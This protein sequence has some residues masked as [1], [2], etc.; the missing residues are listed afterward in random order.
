MLFTGQEMKYKIKD[1]RSKLK[2]ISKIGTVK[3]KI[4]RGDIEKSARFVKQTCTIL[5]KVCLYPLKAYL[6]ISHS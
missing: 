4:L 3:D 1:D 6:M 5:P 2:H